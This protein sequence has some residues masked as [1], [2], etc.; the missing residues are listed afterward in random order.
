MVV[1]RIGVFAGNS[2]GSPPETP[3]VV[4]IM[5]D[6]FVQSIQGALIGPPE[7]GDGDIAVFADN[8]G[9]ALKLLLD[10]VEQPLKARDR[11][12]QGGL[13]AVLGG[14]AHAGPEDRHGKGLGQFVLAEFGP[15]ID[16]GAGGG[17]GRPEGPAIAIARRQ[18]A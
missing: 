17:I 6:P 14:G 16:P 8:V 2:G 12:G 1:S 18:I 10:N 11:G 5:V 15:H 7:I 13:I 9:P 3:A 4:L